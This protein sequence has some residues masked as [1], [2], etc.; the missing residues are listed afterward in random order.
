MT[1]LVTFCTFDHTVEGNP[2]WHGA[3]IL[4]KYN[5]TRKQVEV[6]D[7]WGYYGVPSTGSPDDWLTQLKRNIGLDVDLSGNH[8]W[9][10][11]EEVRFMDMGHGLHGYSYELTEG[12]FNELQDEC[13]ARV[14]AQESAVREVL[15]DKGLTAPPTGKMRCYPGE[16]HSKDVYEIEQRKAKIEQRDPRLHPFDFKLSL[17]WNGPTLKGSHTC[18]TE[19]LSILETVLS[20]ELL[21][22][23]HKS[24]FPRWISGGMENIILHSEGELD[25]HKRSSGKKAY[26]RDGKKEGVKLIWTVPP[27]KIKPL[28][29]SSIDKLWAVDE[30]Y[31]YKAKQVAG[32]LQKLEWMIRQAEIPED[33]EIYRTELLKRIVTFY[34]EFSFINPEMKTP[35]LSGM[36]GFFYSLA[37]LPRNKEQYHLLKQIEQAERLFNSLYMALVHGMEINDKLPPEP[38]FF[39]VNENETDEKFYDENPLEALVSYLSLDDQKKLCKIIGR[40]YCDPDSDDEDVSDERISSALH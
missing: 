2:A 13:H 19:A 22:P 31:C 32:T 36:S 20:P 33:C 4:S 5:E 37:N 38:A 24:T 18:K 11:H 9:L 21:A 12:Q 16:K 39:T 1:Y 29:G 23:Y 10:M 7:T 8:G 34:Q 35:K 26:Y 15:G 27:Q 30:E 40:N 28:P 14:Q 3:F 6:V 25:V 17:G